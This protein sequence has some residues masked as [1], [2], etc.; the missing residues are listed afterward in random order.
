MDNINLY[1]CKNLLQYSKQVNSNKPF[2]FDLKD[3]IK[4]MWEDGIPIEGGTITDVANTI[5]QLTLNNLTQLQVDSPYMS[6]EYLM[7]TI[8]ESKLL[9]DMNEDDATIATCLQ[10]ICVLNDNT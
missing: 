4:S 2:L 8:N 6:R 10:E 1:H 9:Y 7:S 3:L 5:L